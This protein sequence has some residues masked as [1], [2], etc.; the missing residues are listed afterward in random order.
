MK[1]EK[2]D[3]PG[4]T[5]RTKED[6][7]RVFYIRYRRGGREAPLIEEP[8]GSSARGMTAAKANHIRAARINEKA[9]SNKEIR[10]ERVKQAEE[11]RRPRWTLEKLFEEYQTALPSGRGRKVDLVYFK[12]LKTLWA[13]E[14]VEIESAELREIRKNLEKEGLAPQTVKHVLRLFSR[15]LNWAAAPEQEL[16]PMEIAARLKIKMPKVDNAPKTEFLTDEQLERYLVAMDAEKNQD[17][18]ALLRLALF[19]G[20]RKGALLEL[21]WSDIDF[22]RGFITLRAKGAKNEETALLPLN[23]AA[24]AVLEGVERTN[25]E[26]CFPG[27]KG[28]KRA[29]FRRIARRV[30]E[31]VGLPP[32]FRPLHGLRHSYASRIASSGE[33]DM[34]RLQALMTHKTPQMTQRYAHLS[35]EAMRKAAAVTAM[36]MSKPK[37]GEN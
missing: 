25:S 17:A 18:V 6:G 29:D 22:S 34:Y 7:E 16:I 3:Y 20:M 13:K 19:T 2:T 35:D 1:R 14:P 9:P 12:R 15:T 10:R 33:V 26:Y 30:R 37:G 5:V 8:V 32:D 36:V 27:R 24:R 21:K 28:G 11:M 4:V 31:K 23:D